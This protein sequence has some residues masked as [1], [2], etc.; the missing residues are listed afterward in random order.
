[1]LYQRVILPI[2]F[3]L[4]IVGASNA[5]VAARAQSDVPEFQPPVPS[6]LK[7]VERVLDRPKFACVSIDGV[8]LFQIL[9]LKGMAGFDRSLI[10]GAALDRAGAAY[11]RSD[12]SALKVVVDNSEKVDKIVVK[13]GDD[14]FEIMNITPE[15]LLQIGLPGNKPL[16]IESFRSSVERGIRDYRRQR[17]QDYR[18]KVLGLVCASY[19]GSFFVLML[20]PIVKNL[21]NRGLPKH[22]SSIWILLLLLRGVL[23][24]GP[25]VVGSLYVPE[26]RPF[27]TVA[28]TVASRFGICG[29]TGWTTWGMF[30][31]VRAHTTSFGA[32]KA[33]ELKGYKSERIRTE[34]AIQG[35]I[36][37]LVGS[38]SGAFVATSM[39]LGP[40]YLLG[41]LSV[42]VV[43]TYVFFQRQAK[44][45][46][47][48]CW[49]ILRDG[50]YAT[51][52][53]IIV[54]S[55]EGFVADIGLY[56]TILVDAWNPTKRT[57]I[58]HSLLNEHTVQVKT[59]KGKILYDDVFYSAYG[60]QPDRARVSL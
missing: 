33:L 8:C 41:V 9:E 34:T 54:G 11:V 48:G 31:F 46:L 49:Y 60:D 17:Q 45:A 14:Q 2:L 50:T 52:D 19:L 25:V 42:A 27:V 22:K 58:H 20:L 13:V 59:R 15:D 12:A 23:T 44:D 36:I 56:R 28:V 47:A 3:T 6:I 18:I 35:E 55:E 32:F 21:L 26:L 39:L 5:Q 1:V 57:I 43:G 29:V 4:T 40:S 30:R 51:G 16:T 10:I 24:C 38:I 37:D 53:Y 7:E